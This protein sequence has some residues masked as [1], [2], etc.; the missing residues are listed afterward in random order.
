MSEDIFDSLR[1]SQLKGLTIE[2]RRE[3]LH[4]LRRMK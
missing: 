1:D 3:L 2:H 4:S